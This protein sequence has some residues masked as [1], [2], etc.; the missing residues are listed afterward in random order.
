MK[1]IMLLVCMTAAFQA[2]ADMIQVGCVELSAQC[3]TN[4]DGTSGCSWSNGIGK[5]SSIELHK[6]GNGADYEIWK[7]NLTGIINGSYP[8][9]L[10]IYQ[11][12]EAK[13]TFNYLTAELAIAKSK[14]TG[15]GQT[16]VD[17]RYLSEADG[18]GLGLHCTT[19]FQQ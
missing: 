12:R 1:R 11:R 16:A 13:Q 5:L 15:T 14:I 18:F 17:L 3:G 4:P 6:S 7:G 10:W 8:F 2:R 9:Q 19:E